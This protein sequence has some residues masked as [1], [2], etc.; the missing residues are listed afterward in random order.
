MWSLFWA[1]VNRAALGHM[2]LV[3][4]LTREF[5]TVC[6]FSLY[7]HGLSDACLTQSK[8][9][10]LWN[11]Q[12]KMNT[13]HLLWFLDLH[14]VFCCVLLRWIYSLFSVLT[15]PNVVLDS[16]S[17]TTSQHICEKHSYCHKSHLYSVSNNCCCNCSQSCWNSRKACDSSF[18]L[19]NRDLLFFIFYCCVS[20]LFHTRDLNARSLTTSLQSRQQL[21][22]AALL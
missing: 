3:G 15:N 10:C 4:K 2:L 19:W 16:R 7:P 1:F 21:R 9:G 18:K 5:C 22:Q 11:R 8:D 6:K 14:C 20:S 13:L 12:F 17:I